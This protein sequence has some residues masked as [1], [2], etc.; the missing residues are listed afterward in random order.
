MNK[1]IF[2]KISVF[3]SELIGTGF[4]V[5]LGCMGCIK[6]TEADNYAGLSFNF[7]LQ[8][9]I[10]VQIFGCVSG[11]HMN[12][13]V[14]VAAFIYKILNFEML[15]IYVVAQII[16]GFMGFGVLKAVVPAELIRAENSTAPGL[17]STVPHPN[18]TPIQATIIEFLAVFILVTLCCSVW[19][20]RNAK[21]T[22]ST[23][24]KF[25]ICISILAYTIVSR[26][27]KTNEQ[28]KMF[29]IRNIDTKI[30]LQ[31]PLS[32]GSINPARSLGPAIWNGD[33]QHHWVRNSFANARINKKFVFL[34]YTG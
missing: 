32:G 17:C 20:D 23:P 29:V 10:L 28:T 4:L 22:D 27:N 19:D 13:A 31:S 6:Y 24:I 11:A 9:G 12:P 16:G 14:S 26:T 33:F 25:G 8:V 3:V 34:R 30:F 18:V 7:G 1:K 5:F 2:T 21:N 15:A